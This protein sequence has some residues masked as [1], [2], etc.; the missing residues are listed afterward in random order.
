[1]FLTATIISKQTHPSLVG[2]LM[3]FSLTVSDRRLSTP[4]M[5]NYQV[6][7]AYNYPLLIW[8]IIKF[9]SRI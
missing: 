2:Y 1:M 6:C 3:L 7:I 4:N 9:V 8:K 5:E